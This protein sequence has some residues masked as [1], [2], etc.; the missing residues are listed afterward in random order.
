MSDD[1]VTYVVLGL[2]I[3]ALLTMYLKNLCQLVLIALAS[4]KIVKFI[5][6]LFFHNSF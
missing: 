6:L 5:L 2:N 3:N 4:S 1:F